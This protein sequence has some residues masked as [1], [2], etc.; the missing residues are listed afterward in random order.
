MSCVFKLSAFHVS[1]TM[2]TKAGGKCWN[3]H[4]KSQRNNNVAC[5]M[6][7]TFISRFLPRMSKRYDISIMKIYAITQRHFDCC[8]YVT[9]FCTGFQK[10]LMLIMA[11]YSIQGKFLW[12]S[13]NA[14]FRLDISFLFFSHHHPIHSVW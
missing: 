10:F 7:S 5:F 12:W 13:L 6:F 14:W 3:S 8:E 4:I 2:M 9:P 11:L 1:M